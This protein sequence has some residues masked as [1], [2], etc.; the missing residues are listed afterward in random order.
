MLSRI[1]LRSCGHLAVVRKIF[2]RPADHAVAVVATLM[3]AVV[4]RLA[5]HDTIF[6]AVRAA[7]FHVLD[8]MGVHSLEELVP[9]PARF[10]EGSDDRTARRAKLLLSR[11]RQSLSPSR[12]FLRSRSHIGDRCNGSNSVSRYLALICAG[13]FKMISGSPL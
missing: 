3:N 9:P 10:T 8:V 11:Q 4:A 13:S 5:Y 6:D 7:K 2:R 12:E 1:S